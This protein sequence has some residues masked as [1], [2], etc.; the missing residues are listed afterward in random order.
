MYKCSHTADESPGNES[1]LTWW[2]FWSFHLLV[3]SNTCTDIHKK[4]DA[5]KNILI[6][7]SRVFGIQKTADA[8]WTWRPSKSSSF[9]HIS[10][11][12][13]LSYPITDCLLIEDWLTFCILQ[14]NRRLYWKRMLS[15][16]FL[17]IYCQDGKGY[18][19]R[20]KELRGKK[21]WVSKLM[22]SECLEG[23]IFSCL[24]VQ[25]SSFKQDTWVKYHERSLTED[26]LF[27]WFLTWGLNCD[28]QNIL[29]IVISN[30]EWWELSEYLN[31]F[32]TPSYNASA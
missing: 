22:L 20:D 31:S 16:G 8:N 17:L 14:Q 29:N 5:L 10:D 18:S 25:M 23:W 26:T 32:K 30:E 7:V 21:R 9:E 13:V 12:L 6:L 27:P 4:S 24:L 28:L 2:D 1:E 11:Y 19:K 15:L 3:F